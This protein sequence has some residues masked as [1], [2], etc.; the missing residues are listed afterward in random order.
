MK[1]YILSILSIVCALSLISC[2]PLYEVKNETPVSTELQKYARIHIGWIDLNENDWKA[3][4][5][6]SKNQWRSVTCPRNMYHMLS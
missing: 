1:K 6:E 3:F 5:Y 4:G 2:V